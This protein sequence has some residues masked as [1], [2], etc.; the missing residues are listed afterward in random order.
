MVARSHTQQGSDCGRPSS[1]TEN[2][3]KR[4]GKEV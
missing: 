2:L 1:C 4:F 3:T